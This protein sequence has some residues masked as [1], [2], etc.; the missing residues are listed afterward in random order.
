[1]AAEE[2]IYTTLRSLVANGGGSYR[3]YPEAAPQ[4]AVLPY[5]VY[6]RTA[7]PRERTLN[8]SVTLVNPRFEIGCYAETLAD[9]RTLAASVKSAMAGALASLVN[10]L[11]D[12]RL[13][14]DPALGIEFVLLEYSC[15][16]TE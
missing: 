7:A 3:C 5:I 8:N 6:S 13:D 12:D 16:E 15:W 14:F 2:T 9:A 1:M 10:Q 11:D 4:E